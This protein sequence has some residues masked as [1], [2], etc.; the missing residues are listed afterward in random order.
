MRKYVLCWAAYA[1]LDAEGDFVECGAYRGFGVDVVL[2]YLGKDFIGDR[3]FFAYDRYDNPSGSPFDGE[4]LGED[5]PDTLAAITDR[6]HGSSRVVVV[7][8]L[9]P[10]AMDTT[11]PD[12]IAY[13]HIDIANAL[14]TSL[15]LDR[16]LARASPGAVVVLND[17]GW[18]AGYRTVKAAVDEVAAAWGL[19]VVELPT[20]QGI[21]VKTAGGRV[22]SLPPVSLLSAEESLTPALFV[23]DACSGAPDAVAMFK[24]LLKPFEVNRVGNSAIAV[25]NMLIFCRHGG[26][27]SDPRLAA[28]VAAAEPNLRETATLWALHILCWAARA[29]RAVGGCLVVCGGTDFEA[30][31]ILHDAAQSDSG[32][33]FHVYAGIGGS[34][35]PEREKTR[36]AGARVIDGHPADDVDA[37]ADV[38][39]LYLATRDA[40]VDLSCLEV[41]FDRLAIGGILV[42]AGFNMKSTYPEKHRLLEF[43]AGR[44]QMI[45]ELPTGQGLMIRTPRTAP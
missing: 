5:Q 25:E 41:F 33:S 34:H 10:D 30:A 2:R 18:L 43:I 44:G 9:L 37:P 11:C 22:A 14:A 35:G 27:R 31:V 32:T 21:I 28:A 6:F 1:S 12:R 13:A 15:V 17:Y 20:G 45:L 23:P 7:K 39:F 38:A 26:F 8:G 19:P 40:D 36:R 4:D 24:R 3:R 16:V 29:S 42:I